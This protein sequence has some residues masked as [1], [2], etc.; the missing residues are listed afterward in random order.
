[1]SAHCEDCGSRVYGGSCVD[2]DE[3]TF[4]AQ[5]YMEAGESV[6]VIIAEAA[7]EQ[8]QRKAQKE[9]A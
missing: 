3:E 1:M 8:R 4:I 2:C 9:A 5:Q 7:E 6:P